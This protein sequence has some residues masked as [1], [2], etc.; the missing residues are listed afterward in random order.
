MAGGSAKAVYAAIGANS[1]VMVIKFG[2]FVATGSGT[3]LA[4]A[5]HSLADV[6]NQTLLAV[7]MNRSHRPADDDH[8]FGY[9]REAFVWALI[10]AVG[11][12]FLG[13]GVSVTHGVLSLLSNEH[14]EVGS[15]TLNLSILGLSLVAEGGSLLVAVRAI[16]SDAKHRGMGFWEHVRTTS[17][18][19]GVAVLL[20]DSAA[21]FGVIFAFAAVGLGALTGNANIDAYGSIGIGILLGFVAY[22]LIIRNRKLLIGEAVQGEDKE[23]M[24][25]VLNNDPMVDKVIVEQSLVTGTNSYRVTAEVDLNGAYLA[26]RYIEKHGIEGVADKLDTDEAL[27]QFLY[28]YTDVITDMVGE[29]IDRIEARMSQVLPQDVHLDV[30]PD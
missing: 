27:T 25:A 6:G 3:M 29:E 24:M 4:E 22:F 14:H 1:F 19:F 16:A 11:I 15:P 7:G 5:I 9:A 26:D 12:F 20:E 13:C 8:P 18:P 17:D 21:V 2:G 23:K 10:S 28:G 30:E